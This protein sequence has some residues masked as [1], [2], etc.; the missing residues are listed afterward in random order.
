MPDRVAALEVV[1]AAGRRRAV[2][3]ARLPGCPRPPRGGGARDL[4]DRRR[5]AEHEVLAERLFRVSCMQA[6][7]GEPTGTA[8]GGLPAARAGRRRRRASG[9]ASAPSDARSVP[10][11][12]GPGA[13][14]A[15]AGVPRVFGDDRLRIL[16]EGA[17]EERGVERAELIA[18]V[19]GHVEVRGDGR[20]RI[21][22]DLV[23][24][25][26]REDVTMRSCVPFS[27]RARRTGSENWS[28]S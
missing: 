19:L 20:V 15:R 10:V 26:L 23:A 13:G 9:S 28:V 16:L 17:V 18:R 8:R 22:R 3:E 25:V 4:H 2:L 1:V 6:C 7:D 12:R 5:G 11:E 14:I 24:L 21:V 27:S